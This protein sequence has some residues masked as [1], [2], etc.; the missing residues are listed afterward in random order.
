MS[1]EKRTCKSRRSIASIVEELRFAAP[2]SVSAS[3]SIYSYRRQW[4]VPSR[5]YTF[6]WIEGDVAPITVSGFADVA[7]L[8][9][10]VM[11]V[12][13]SELKLIDEPSDPDQLFSSLSQVASELG[14]ASSED[15]VI[16]G[17]LFHIQA[18]DSIWVLS[19]SP[20]WSGTYN[21]RKLLDFGGPPL[22]EEHFS[23]K[24]WDTLF[25]RLYYR[26][27]RPRLAKAS[28]NIRKHY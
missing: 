3:A 24:H 28:L 25:N 13:Q 18:V 4:A 11:N 15:L 7:K 10:A 5:A 26:A 19:E 17:R 16:N 20:P 9:D 22:W 6:K 8:S 21:R 1:S 12:L 27:T 2:T 14:A 23:P